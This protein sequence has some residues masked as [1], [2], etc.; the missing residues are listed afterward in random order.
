MATEQKDFLLS[1]PEFVSNA[2]VLLRKLS[3]R[4]PILE[5]DEL[6]AMVRCREQVEKELKDP[7]ASK[8]NAKHVDVFLRRITTGLPIVSPSDQLALAQAR[9]TL[10]GSMP[11]AP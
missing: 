10:E 8:L 9:V 5:L 7:S 6:R 11:N 3:I 1:D 4:E 2:A